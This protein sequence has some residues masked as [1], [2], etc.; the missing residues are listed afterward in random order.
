MARSEATYV[1]FT[2]EIE[3]DLDQWLT[4]DII[5]KFGAQG[6]T[7]SKR[8]AIRK[9]L[10]WARELYEAGHPIRITV[11]SGNGDGSMEAEIDGHPPE[12]GRGDSTRTVG[13]SGSHDTELREVAVVHSGT[14]A[15]DV[16]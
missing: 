6:V 8:E 1:R 3:P 2:M 13:G 9:V 14:V 5:A 10:R 15:A 11:E 7:L 4:E 12:G 16:A